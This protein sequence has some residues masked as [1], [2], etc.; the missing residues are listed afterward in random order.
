MRRVAQ[1]AREI[2]MGGFGKNVTYESDD[3][4]GELSDAFNKM[5]LALHH[6]SNDF[7]R[8]SDLLSKANGE[9]QRRVDERTE[10]LKEAQQNLIQAA[11]LAAVGEMGAGLAHSLNN[12][13]A[14]V[15]G[16]IQ[17]LISKYSEDE[18][19]LLVR[20][21]AR[22]CRDIV[23]QWLEVS[24]YLEKVDTRD[25]KE[26]SL[27]S[28]IKRSVS[29][30]STYLSQ[31]EVSV[32]LAAIEDCL[33]TADIRLMEQAFTQFFYAVRHQ[34]EHGT[35]II[36]R[37]N[38][39]R[40][41]IVLFISYEQAHFTEDDRKAAGMF[42]WSSV[43]YFSTHRGEIKRVKNHDYHWTIIIPKEIE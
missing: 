16:C 39:Q 13:L 41:G 26:V 7:Q 4:I 36:M 19:L 34:V 21:E 28:I 42:Y 2:A 11:R 5:S 29:A 38:I 30:S 14:S 20:D 40:D 35:N 15:L 23:S 10:E 33:L 31:R 37:S 3:E 1:A 27:L 6:Y 12:P 32:E 43:H 9:L 18:L 22:K 25:F 17:I 8:Q 24:K